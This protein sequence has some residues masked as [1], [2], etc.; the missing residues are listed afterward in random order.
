MDDRYVS[1]MVFDGHDFAYFQYKY[2][3]I[4]CSGLAF[5]HIM[6]LDQQISESML[7]SCG[8]DN[9]FLL[10]QNLVVDKETHE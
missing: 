10:P 8:M 3:A 6:L 5:L 1:K 4:L 9:K 7:I 2:F